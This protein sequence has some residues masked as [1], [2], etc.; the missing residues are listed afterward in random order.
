MR[1]ASWASTVGDQSGIR[2]TS[3]LLISASCKHKELVISASSWNH[4]GLRSQF[5][6][7]RMR[8]GGGAGSMKSGPWCLLR[9]L[10]ATLDMVAVVVVLMREDDVR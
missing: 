3:R 7:P 8:L 6:T 2:I 1:P 4:F 10:E 9:V 5:P